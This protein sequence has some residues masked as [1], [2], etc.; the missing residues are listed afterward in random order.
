[1]VSTHEHPRFESPALQRGI[2]KL[3]QVDNFTNLFFVATEH[4]CLFAVISS[5]VMNAKVNA[6][7]PT[8]RARCTVARPARLTVSRMSSG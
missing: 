1:M 4:F 7:S 8:A 3:R 6:V 2:T 5:T